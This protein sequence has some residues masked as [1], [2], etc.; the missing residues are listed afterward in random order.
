[1]RI[2]KG[3]LM[4]FSLIVF[5]SPAG[6][7]RA[8]A[9]KL[10]YSTYLGGS[11][12]DQANGVAAAP[13][14]TVL[15]G[16]TNSA[17]F[18]TA[19]A[20][21]P[22][23]AGGSYDAFVSG[24]DSSGD[25]AFST[26]LGGADSDAAWAVGLRLGGIYVAGQTSSD[27]FPTLNSWQASRAG[28]YDA[29]VCLLDSSGN[30]S[31]STYLGG[32]GAENGLAAAW[33]LGEMVVA[34]Y[35]TSLDFPTVQPF[36]AGYA[37]GLYDVFVSS[38]GS[39]GGLQF[40]SYLGGQSSDYCYDVGVINGEIWASGDSNSVNFPTVDPI[41]AGNAGNLDSFLCR[42][43]DDRA[44]GFSTYLGGSS[45]E[46]RTALAVG[47]DSVWLTGYTTSQDFPTVSAFQPS[48]A[49][50]DSDAFVC[51]IDPSPS[52]SFSTYF[53][54]T[55][56]DEGIGI[57]LEEDEASIA[58]YT[59]SDDF[60]TVNPVYP[61]RNF[62]N[63]DAFAAS[64]SSDGNP[65]FST[66]LGG[67]MH[68]YGYQIARKSGRLILA[69]DTASDNFPTLDPYQGTLAGDWDA[70][71]TIFV[72]VTPTPAPSLTPAPTATTTAA[73][74]RTPTPT[75][76]QTVPPTPVP[77]LTPVRTA[78]PQGE[79]SP[80]PSCGPS[81]VPERAV[82]ESGDYNGDGTADVAVFRPP[83]GLWSVRNVTRLNF[84]NSDDQPAPGDFNGDGTARIAIYR[85]ATGL[86]SISGVTRAFFGGAED[87]AAPAD[88]NGD[89]TCEVAVFRENGGMWS[90][91]SL[92]RFYFG[93]TGDWAIPGDYSDDGT[94]E[95]TL[96]RVESGQWMVRDL[97]RFYFGNSDDWPVPGGYF[98]SSEK[99]FAIFRPCSGQWALRD[100]TRIY[101][102]NCFDYPRP[103]DFN[104]DGEDD[105]G[106]F[107]DS[108][109]MWS[110]RNLTRVYF[111]STG[112]IPVTR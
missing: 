11:G 110:V 39:G 108:A 71:L 89:G 15:A 94:A 25:L 24:F 81:V 85:P 66:Y 21:Q 54:G 73:P 38:F 31:S 106:I 77:T 50:G 43:D 97:T 98:G 86:W 18:P 72:P 63:F 1:M 90:V 100:L 5:L 3:C 99:V 69:G 55:S 10:V 16:T 28:G 103:G 93:A 42:I 102:G 14:L 53:G 19:S 88:Y 70:F 30:L 32:T 84:G 44:L 40:S 109:G 49:G 76:A 75:P 112:D 6:G 56:D 65:V 46:G 48:Y 79:P 37:G 61:A 64:F 82:I 101:F 51:R 47:A 58:G 87:R 78:T 52:L 8:G 23:Y 29:F 92:T 60:P 9:M 104:G 107:R 91:R 83:E 95:A 74:V 41:Q 36:Q 27:D 80:T 111:G 12:Y 67:R 33:E 59:S 4:G 68:D 20:F 57:D 45:N 105:F 7:A 96:Y 35:T 17:D 2:G 13:G 62:V 26:Y 22:S 34:G